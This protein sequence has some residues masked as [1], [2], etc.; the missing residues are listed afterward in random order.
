MSSN[1]IDRRQKEIKKLQIDLQ[2]LEKD[3][4]FFYI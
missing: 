3:F 2:E 1:E 4:S